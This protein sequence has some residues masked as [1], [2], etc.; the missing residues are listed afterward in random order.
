MFQRYLKSD[1][2]LIGEDWPRS[3]LRFP[4]YNDSGSDASTSA[5]QAQSTSQDAAAEE[6]LE[7]ACAR[8]SV[9][10]KAKVDMSHSTRW[11]PIT[12]ASSTA[13]GVS[14]AQCCA[15]CLIHAQC[16]AWQLEDPGFC[17]LLQA[18]PAR[19]RIPQPL[20][21]A[22]RY[23]KVGLLSGLADAD[24]MRQDENAKDGDEIP[25]VTDGADVQG[26]EN[27]DA[28]VRSDD[29]RQDDGVEG[30]SGGNGAVVGREMARG[31]DG[32]GDSDEVVSNVESSRGEQSGGGEGGLEPAQPGTV[33]QTGGGGDGDSGQDQA[34]AS[35]AAGAGGQL[36][37]GVTQGQGAASES[38]ADADQAIS[39][40]GGSSETSASEHVTEHEQENGQEE[41]VKQGGEEDMIQSKGGLGDDQNGESAG[42][43]E[44]DKTREPDSNGIS[45]READEIREVAGGMDSDTAGSGDDAADGTDGRE[46]GAAVAETSGAAP[47]SSGSSASTAASSPESKATGPTEGEGGAG[48]KTSGFGDAKFDAEI[49]INFKCYSPS[50]VEVP[51]LEDGQ[52]CGDDDSGR[53]TATKFHC[54]IFY[55]IFSRKRVVLCGLRALCV[56]VKASLTSLVTT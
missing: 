32:V 45:S 14:E 29:G 52:P 1:P 25:A 37:Q 41:N 15:L 23:S 55:F 48:A 7:G 40:E 21:K 28:Q 33:Q 54:V 43:G 12:A 19:G 53:G 24:E 4:D 49:G 3:V 10:D 30:E 39:G 31:A 20:L 50:G 17:R 18:L 9:T 11:A 42:V 56:V 47:D 22:D 27:A 46:E 38:Q 5:V 44:N 2:Y 26:A 51:C 6:T 36:G 16:Q 34:V 8:F 13:S 35:E